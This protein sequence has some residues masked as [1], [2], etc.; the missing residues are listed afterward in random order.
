[1]REQ[2]VLQAGHPL[3]RAI[4]ERVFGWERTDNG[5]ALPDGDFR[6]RT[7]PYSTDTLRAWS[8]AKYVCRTYNVIGTVN[9][10]DRDYTCN[11]RKIGENGVTRLSSTLPHAICLAVLG[12]LDE[13]QEG[14]VIR[15]KTNQGSLTERLRDYRNFLQ[16]RKDQADQEVRD[17]LDDVVNARQQNKREDMAGLAGTFFDSATTAYNVNVDLEEFE[18]LFG[19]DLGLDEPDDWDDVSASEIEAR[20]QMEARFPGYFDEDPF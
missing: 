14:T 1:M 19:P 6:I 7:P 12:L 9:M 4:A 15:Q 17:W 5:W 18:R 20:R 10:F 16:G 2:P 3:D 11:F 8:L 13:R